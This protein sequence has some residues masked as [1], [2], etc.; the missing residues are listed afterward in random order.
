[1]RLQLVLDRVQLRL[2]HD[3]GRHRFGLRG[4]PPPELAAPIDIRGEWRG[5]SVRDWQQAEGRLY[6]RLDYADVAAW[7]EWLPLPTEIASGKGALRLWFEFAGGMAR[8]ITGDVELEDVEARLAD[9]LPKLELTHL[10]GRIQWQDDDG[11]REFLAR[12][13]R[14]SVAGGAAL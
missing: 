12:Q 4:T 11:R 10:A 8:E 6:A 14:F 7:R 5:G 2:E 13:L 3:F 1:M 9:T